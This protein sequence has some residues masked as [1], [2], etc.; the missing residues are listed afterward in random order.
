M[1]EMLLRPFA[2]AFLS[3]VQAELDHV[4]RPTD[5]PQYHAPGPDPDRV[6]VFGNGPAMGFGVRTQELALPGQIGRRLSAATGRGADIDLVARRR[7]SVEITPPLIA[8]LR[9]DR[10]DGIVVVIGATDAAAF[11]S[12]RRWSAA[13][14]RL[15]EELTRRS[16]PG[17]P[18][19]VLGIH[20]L[21]RSALTA[22]VLGD[23]VDRHARRLNAATR[24]LC[25]EDPGLTYVDRG[26]EAVRG[27]QYRSAQAFQLLAEMIVPALVPGLDAAAAH[28]DKRSARAV[29][30]TPA[31]EV[32]RQSALDALEVLDTAPEERFD[33]IVR[34]ARSTFG[35][36]FAAISLV[37]RERQWHK[38]VAGPEDAPVE[39]PREVALCHRTIRHDRPLVVADLRNDPHVHP[40]LLAAG[41]R[42]YAGYP[43]ESPDGFRI[44]A[45]CVLDTEPRPGNDVD[46]TLLRDLALRVQREMWTRP[47]GSVR[48]SLPR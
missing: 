46:T 34:S 47:D 13:M 30:D 8:R 1:I 9:P 36:T 7:T 19:V 3:R 11:L 6:L 26:D 33:R 45:L 20:S 43:I 37:D 31:A 18:I 14:R 15:L 38:A 22:G 4:P 21:R 10:Y 39:L 35:A 12:V 25:A 23:L 17:T 24:A 48:E 40:D 27:V 28:P 44:G 41:W 2:R 16:A 42:F 29:R 5:P 32:S